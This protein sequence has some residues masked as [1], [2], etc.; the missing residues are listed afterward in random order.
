MASGRINRNV[1]SRGR[2]VAG[3]PHRVRHTNCVVRSWWADI[4]TGCT[5][6]PRLTSDLISRRTAG[7][8]SSWFRGRVDTRRTCL[9]T[10]VRRPSSPA[11][12]TRV[13]S[14][15]QGASPHRGCILRNQTL[16]WWV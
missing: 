6:P 8:R 5:D 15:G 13:R 4:Q 16:A 11:D 10:S 2:T 12:P 7:V 1:S 3:I 14:N 9:T